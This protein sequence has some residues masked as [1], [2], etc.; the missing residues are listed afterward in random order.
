VVLDARERL[1]EMFGIRDPANIFFTKNATEALNIAIYGTLRPGD[2]AVTTS[3][4]HNS[5]MRPLAHLGAGGVELAVAEARPTGTVPPE[6]VI[7]AV[8]PNTRL[9]AVTHA[10][11]V[12]GAVNDIGAIGRFCSERGIPFLVDAAQTAGVVPIDVERD[13]VDLLAFSGHKGLLGPQGTGALYA[14]DGGALEPLMRGGTGSLSDRE[15]QPG[16][17]P[18]K[19]ECGTL[20]TVGIA[21]LGAGV[22]FIRRFGMER[23]LERDGRL[24]ELLLAQLGGDER[25]TIFGPR[26][27]AR[28]TG[29]VSLN[30]VGRSPSSVGEALDREY[31][32][33]TRVGLHCAPRAHKTIGTF[34]DGTVRL[35]WGVFTSERDI[36]RAC[37]ALKRIAWS[38]YTRRSG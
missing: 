2:H 21:G 23:V 14:R 1:A 3:M 12:T 19:F 6:A 29:V 25:F 20:N 24:L 18:D 5:V 33:Q 37:R 34:P 36:L 11:N 35:S 30:V 4:E 22:A 13:R 10:S 32:I 17:L 27:A 9:V 7:R 31:G 28:Q 8:K 38:G 15:E 16:F 26:D